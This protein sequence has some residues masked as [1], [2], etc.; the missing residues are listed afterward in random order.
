M[1][2]SKITESQNTRVFAGKKLFVENKG[3]FLRVNVKLFRMA[4]FKRRNRFHYSFLLDKYNYL[5]AHDVMGQ[6][7]VVVASDVVGFF[8][9]SRI[10]Q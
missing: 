7:D 6:R 4:I 3:T 8:F 10:H 9:I 2:D 5:E 1:I